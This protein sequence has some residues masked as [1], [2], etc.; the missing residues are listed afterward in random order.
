MRNTSVELVMQVVR[1]IEETLNEPLLLDNIARSVFVS[2]YHLHRL[3]KTLT[4]R[5][6]MSYVRGRRLSRSLDELLNTQEKLSYIAEMYGFNYE[7]S[8][9]RAFKSHFGMTPTAF[10]NAPNELEIV[11]MFDTST[12]RDIASGIFV[13]PRF[14]VLPEMMFTGIR[15]SIS[16]QP[17][18]PTAANEAALRFCDSER[19]SIPH[20]IN[21]QLYYGFTDDINERSYCYMSCVETNE[22]SQLPMPFESFVLPSHLY[23]VFR[24]VGFHSA[25]CLSDYTLDEIYNYISVDWCAKTDYRRD[26][27]YMFERVDATVCKS[28]YCEMDIFLPVNDKPN[29]K[30]S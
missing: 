22:L 7:Q 8:Y 18:R 25:D 19:E 4:G 15:H 9:E 16:L 27:D 1:L 2:K 12:I 10:R 11:H 30:D 5:T 29:Q 6:L 3:F 17:K 13:A 21:E 23:A 24:Y 14:L 28:T 26:N 20:R